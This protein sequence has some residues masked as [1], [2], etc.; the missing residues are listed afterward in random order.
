[1]EPSDSEDFANRGLTISNLPLPYQLH[2]M[3][4]IAL[5]RQARQ[6]QWLRDYIAWHR[7]TKGTKGARYLLWQCRT[8]GYQCGGLGD[9]MRGIEWS[10]RLAVSMKV[11]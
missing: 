6:P 3:E 8:K 1:M 7:A 4:T 2:S 5:M 10:L 11:W 9:R